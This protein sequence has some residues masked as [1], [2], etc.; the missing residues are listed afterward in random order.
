MFSLVVM[1]NFVYWF[2]LVVN[3]FDVC[4]LG[5]CIRERVDFDGII[6]VRCCDMVGVVLVSMWDR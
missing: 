6:V 1:G 3:K 2:Y 5:V 4:F